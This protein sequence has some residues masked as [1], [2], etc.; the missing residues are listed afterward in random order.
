MTL[1]VIRVIKL[2]EAEVHAPGADCSKTGDGCSQL[3]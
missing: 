3:G 2:P 1:M